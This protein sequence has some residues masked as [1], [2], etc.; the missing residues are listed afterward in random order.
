MGIADL[1]GMRYPDEYLIRFFYK[2]GLH[3]QPGRALELGSGSA[4][5]LMHFAAYGWEAIGIDYDPQC[6]ADGRHNLTASGLAGELIQH[7]LDTGL[8]PLAGPFHALLAPST[9]YYIRRESAWACMRQAAALL[10]PG[11]ALYLRMRLPDDYRAGRGV[12]EGEGGWRLDTDYTGEQGALNV[13]WHEHEL[14]DLL[15][16]TLGLTP[17]RLTLL[18]V[19]YDN[20]QGGRLIRNSDIVI[21][22]R[23]P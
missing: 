12:P 4:N 11:A 7:D 17:E 23:L 16:E 19:A 13:F 14:L 21:W 20:V 6:V 10:A 15:R 2:E 9:L 3:R 1:R 22:G 5:N 8:P 18:R